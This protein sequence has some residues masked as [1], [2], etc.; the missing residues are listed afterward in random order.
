MSLLTE[1]TIL[2]NSKVEKG[3]YYWQKLNDYQ[4]EDL[5]HLLKQ[6]LIDVHKEKFAKVLAEESDMNADD[7][8]TIVQEDVNFDEDLVMEDMESN[9]DVEKPNDDGKQ[10]QDSNAK[11]AND[12]KPQVANE[13]G[14]EKN[15]V[16]M[17]N[18]EI[19]DDGENPNPGKAI[20]N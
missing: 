19:G 8:F 14:D 16:N 9:E 5:K 12:G 11:M 15:D 7:G 13:H 2:K 6:Y 3:G 4:F 10:N 17:M 18:S 20:E 1:R